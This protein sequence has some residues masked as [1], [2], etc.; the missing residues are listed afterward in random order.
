MLKEDPKRA[1]EVFQLLQYNE[2][3]S[4]GRGHRL[5]LVGRQSPSRPVLAATIPSATCSERPFSEIWDDP[6]IELLHK[7]KNK[8]AICE[9]TLRLLPLPEHL[10]RQLPLPCPKPIT[11]T[12]G[13]RIP[14]VT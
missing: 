4:S 11:A 12:N 7:M 5:Y 10:R 3:N 1:E 8:K 6:N 13:P 2:G 14:P 9:G